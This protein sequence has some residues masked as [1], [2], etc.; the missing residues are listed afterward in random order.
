M[1]L[2][3]LLIKRSCHSIIVSWLK[4]HD[5]RSPCLDH[6][7]QDQARPVNGLCL[8]IATLLSLVDRL[9]EVFEC[10]L[11]HAPALRPRPFIREAEMDAL[12]DAD[13]DRIPG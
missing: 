13:I 3:K 8:V 12:V 10:P 6:R 9:Q 5:Q 7:A 11:S 2:E 1:T 4:N